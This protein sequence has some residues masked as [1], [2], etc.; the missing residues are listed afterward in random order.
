MKNNCWKNYII[1]YYE[2]SSKNYAI[3]SFLYNINANANSRKMNMKI[4]N[5]NAEELFAGEENIKRP[6]L[7]MLCF[8]CGLRSVERSL[9]PRKI[10][11]NE[12]NVQGI[13]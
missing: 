7:F 2:L 9:C 11:T 8:V 5:G 1:S 10:K 13:N 4:F 12:H 6:D 3:F